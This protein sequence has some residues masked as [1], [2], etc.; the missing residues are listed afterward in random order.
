M[1]DK[2]VYKRQ[3]PQAAGIATCADILST[4]KQLVF[5]EKRY[6]GDEL[7]QAVY[8]NWEGHDQLDVYKR[9]EL[10]TV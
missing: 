9:Q 3:A 7:L 10:T 8:D 1:I 2:D 5:E 6:T 4:I